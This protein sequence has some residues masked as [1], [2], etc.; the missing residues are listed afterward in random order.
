MRYPQRKSFSNSLNKNK[1]NAEE[2][3]NRSPESSDA[4]CTSTTPQPPPTGARLRGLAFAMLGRREH[5]EQEFKQKL[6]DL[7]ADPA[8]V[9]ELVKEFQTSQYQSDQRMA[10]MIVRANVRK[11]RGP[12]RVKQTLRERSVDAELAQDHLAETD[13]L[14]LARA[15]RVKKFG[16]EL[17]T[18]PK[19]K[20]RQLRFLQYRGYDMQTCSQAIGRND[21]EEDQ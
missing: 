8:E 2:N 4:D 19:E 20:A 16:L 6:L 12:V 5:S 13:W 21:C 18:D 3:I 9:D 10:D 17:P 1:Q 15:L 11:G 7:E 14:A